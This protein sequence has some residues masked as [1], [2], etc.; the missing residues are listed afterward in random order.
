MESGQM[1]SFSAYNCTKS[2]ALVLDIQGHY[3]S[4]NKINLSGF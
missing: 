1:Y 4:W 3:L 2:T